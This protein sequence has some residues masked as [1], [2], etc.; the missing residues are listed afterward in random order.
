MREIVNRAQLPNFYAATDPS[1]AEAADAGR[2]DMR[3]ARG[4][5]VPLAVAVAAPGYL[6]PP[7]STPA[8]RSSTWLRVR[9]GCG[10]TAFPTTCGQATPS[11]FPR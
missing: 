1:H 5:R 11:A 6:P 3:L 10:S 4:A 2:I 7:T 8:N 9:S